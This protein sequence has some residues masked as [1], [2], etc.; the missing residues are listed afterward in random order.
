MRTP[1]CTIVNAELELSLC[2]YTKHT[3]QTDSQERRSLT[4]T[5]LRLAPVEALQLRPDL[6][7]PRRG[8]E[9]P[10]SQGL[11]HH[12]TKL[13]R[14][15]DRVQRLAAAKGPKTVWLVKL[16]TATQLSPRQR[17]HKASAAVVET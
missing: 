7:S 17:H 13:N 14:M 5:A 6:P 11:S 9:C 1:P 3:P 4:S 8:F 12:T 16:D 10:R 15:V 2:R